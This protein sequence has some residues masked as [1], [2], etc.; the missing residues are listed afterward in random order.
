MD[1]P[2]FR[3]ESLANL[4]VVIW[5]L[6]LMGGSL[7]LAL[8]GKCAWLGGI[9][10]YPEVVAQ[11][12]ERCIIDQGSIRPKDVLQGADIIILSTPVRAILSSLDEIAGEIAG[13][14]VV[15][16]L[17]S[18]KRE[19]L[20]K[21]DGLPERFDPVGGHPMCGKEKGTLQNADAAIYRGAPFALVSHPQT[22]PRARGL[23]EEITRCIGSVPFWI[24][25][26]THDRWV[27]ASSHVP[28]LVANALAQ[29][30]PL[31]A[32]PLIG[33]GFRSTARLAGSSPKMMV[34]IL[35]TNGDNIMHMIAQFRKYLDRYEQL[36]EQKE[37]LTLAVEFERG[38]EQYRILA[39]DR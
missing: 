30:T 25:A 38:A 3:H 23:V 26:E 34:D 37:F 29:A 35:E 13:Q 22:S 16:D 10:L 27:A 17:G 11:A 5:G 39:N 20:Q 12:K 2:G 18:T 6:G 9:D 28:F 33:P 32:L 31:D 1:E 19:I 14:A 7:A 24:D 8:K 15:F 21:M 36:L 4:R